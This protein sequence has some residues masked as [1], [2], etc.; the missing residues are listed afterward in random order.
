[1]RNFFL[2]PFYF[3]SLTLKV[4]E[5]CWLGGG[6]KFLYMHYQYSKNHWYWMFWILRER[7]RVEVLSPFLYPLLLFDNSVM[8]FLITYVYLM[9]VC[10]LTP[11]TV[12]WGNFIGN[13]SLIRQYECCQRRQNLGS[14]LLSYIYVLVFLCE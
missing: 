14:L 8:L 12:E 13:C 11:Y 10:W 6:A 2:A 7:E 1:M 4:N 9:H 3:Q 5:W